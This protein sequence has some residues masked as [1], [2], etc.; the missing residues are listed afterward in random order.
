MTL[1]QQEID[2]FFLK[3][4][5]TFLETYQGELPTSVTKRYPSNKRAF[6]HYTARLALL[7]SL[8]S[9]QYLQFQSYCD[10]NIINHHHMEKAKDALVSLSH[11]SK[12]SMASVT[13][14]CDIQ[15]IG[16]DLES[17]D[18][19][20][21]KGIEKFF[22]NEKDEISDTLHLWCIKEAA[23]K[24]ISPL[25]KGEK[26]L[27][28]KDIAIQANGRFV[29]LLDEPIQGYWKIQIESERVFS[30]ALILKSSQ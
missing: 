19:K 3:I 16:I 24:A 5:T 12:F 1:M 30:H 25:Y 20:I 10:L 22:L 29:L 2:N 15:S 6:E 21:K 27:V 17:V 11:T 18:R 26:Q 23:F 8:K 28:L 14:S 13:K 9:C 4:K 7:E